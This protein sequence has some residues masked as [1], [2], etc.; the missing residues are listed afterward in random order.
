MREVDYTFFYKNSIRLLA[1]HKTFLINTFNIPFISKLMF[2][3]SLNRIED[4]DEVQGYNYL[5]LFRFFFG[6]NGFLT[7][8]RSYFSLGKWTYSFNA[9][10]IIN[11][12]DVYNILFLVLNDILS[13]TDRGYLSSGLFS[14]N[15]NIYYLVFKDVNI[16]SEKK[17]N[18]GLFSLKRNLNFRIY[19][20]GCEADSFFIH[21]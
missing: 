6:R 5:Y 18:L 14:K 9:C 20:T 8:Y 3:F 4:K 1:M 19:C 13:V 17:T 12:K 21:D 11:K 16:F 7:K 15:N 2:I 10:L